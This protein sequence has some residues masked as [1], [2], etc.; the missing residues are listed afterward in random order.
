MPKRCA[1]LSSSLLSV[2]YLVLLTNWCRASS[3]Q[4]LHWHH[5]CQLLY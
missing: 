4:K 2:G 5:H 3:D 1:S